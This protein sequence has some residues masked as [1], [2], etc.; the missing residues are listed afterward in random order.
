MEGVKNIF[1][2]AFKVDQ[3]QECWQDCEVR[4]DVKVADIALRSG[5]IVCDGELDSVEDLKGGNG[6]LGSLKVTNLRLL[7]VSNEGN[8]VNNLSIGYGTITSL[9]LKSLSSRLAGNAT[10]MHVQA[11]ATS[12]EGRA[13]KGAKF[14]FIFSVTGPM[15]DSPRLFTSIQ[16]VYRAY[17]TTRM[18]R[19]LRL[20]CACIKDAELLTLPQETITN[21]VPGVWNLSSDAGNLGVMFFTNIRF[22]WH[23]LLAENFNVSVPWIQIKYVKLKDTK[24]GRA[25]C[26]KCTD[27]SGGYV[28][29]FR[30]DP[31]DKVEPLHHELRALAATY[32][33]NPY[34]GIVATGGGALEMATP[35]PSK[36]RADDVEIVDSTEANFDALA[37]YYADA[38]GR[39]G[40]EA[41]RRIYLDPYL[42]LA[43]ESTEA[44]GRG[45]LTLAD[46][47]SVTSKD[48]SRQ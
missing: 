27:R 34:L 15:R 2:N 19:E 12:G 33:Q 39:S 7:W 14:E 4:F 41:D 21:K 36:S 6:E 45:D 47:W 11:R 1:S 42:G 37:A 29:G 5:E 46:L 48:D 18:Y 10:A 43:V 3:D 25:L 16:A 32:S 30:V 40:E 9:T 22:V 31:A 38:G 26:V 20:R 44:L 24:F 35:F 8:S 17:D 13:S 28:L 23:A